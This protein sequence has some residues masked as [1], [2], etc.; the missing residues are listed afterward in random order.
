MPDISRFPAEPETPALPQ[1][2]TPA[3]FRNR[4]RHL[5]YGHRPAAV[6]F[7][8]GLLALD[9][10]RVHVDR[11]RPGNDAPIRDIL[12]ELRAGGVRAVAPDGVL[13]DPTGATAGE[14]RM[15]LASMVDGAWARL[16]SGRIDDRG[17]LVAGAATPDPTIGAVS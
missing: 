1:P 6:A 3:G 11:L 5:F 17:C 7:Q 9:P 2:R 8:A 12:G 15:L 10:A 13:G 16:R 14:G 4:L